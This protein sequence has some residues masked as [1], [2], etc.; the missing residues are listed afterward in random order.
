MSG[1]VWNSEIPANSGKFHT[2]INL[3]TE[4][5]SLCS[6]IFKMLYWSLTEGMQSLTEGYVPIPDM[7]DAVPERGFL[8][9]Q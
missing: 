6:F 2:F 3:T 9:L 8:V 1:S 5:K 7:G 4:V